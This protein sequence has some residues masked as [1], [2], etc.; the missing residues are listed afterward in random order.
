MAWFLVIVEGLLETEP[1]RTAEEPKL[2]IRLR[3]TTVTTVTGALIGGV[4]IVSII[5]QVL[6][7]HYEMPFAGMIRNFDLNSEGNV[8]TLLSTVLLTIAGGLLLVIARARKRESASFALHWKTLAFIFFFMA[9]DEAIGIHELLIQPLRSALNAEGFLYFTW[10]LPGGILVFVFAL[11]YL[12]FLFHLPR[13]VAVLFAVA[14][15][16]YVLGALGMEM[17]SGNYYGT[18]NRPQDQ[19]YA[20]LTT[21]EEVLEMVGVAILIHALASYMADHVKSVLIRFD[22]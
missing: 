11:S 15:A 8:P 3:P 21:I 10:V 7:F 17:I 16:T 2:S 19:I 13:K 22:R 14:G 4:V 9:V 12:R 5:M 20:L 18:H 6:R 1:D